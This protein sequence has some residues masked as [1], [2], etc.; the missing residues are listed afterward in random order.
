[1]TQSPFSLSPDG[2]VVRIA[3][4]PKAGANRIDGVIDRPDGAAL[5]VRVTAVPE[6][7]KANAALIKLLAKS[8]GIAGGRL[9][10]I[11]GA[12]DRQKRLLIANGDTDLQ[13]RLDII[14]RALIEK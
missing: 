9:S 5:K 1:M 4:I 10:L 3:L 13:Q 11:S 2:V 12:K 14:T 7:G 8:L 6:K